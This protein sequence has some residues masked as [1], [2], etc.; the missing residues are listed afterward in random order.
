MISA[1]LLCLTFLPQE[2][3]PYVLWLKNNKRMK[4]Q[5]PPDCNA[6]RCL[7]TLLNGE[8]T[9]LP[10]GLVDLERSK[11]YNEELATKREEARLAKEK[12]AAEKA[13]A[14]AKEAEKNK[15]RR[16]V[17]TADDELP[18][19]DRSRA[20]TSGTASPDTGGGSLI[21]EPRV[22]TFSSDQPVYVAR[23]VL[24]RYEDRTVLACDV[25]V[26]GVD[27]VS[28]VVVSVQVNFDTAPTRTMSQT[29]TTPLKKGDVATA[30]FTIPENDEILRVSY[31]V[32][33][34]TVETRTE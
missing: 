26:A 18:K 7:V 3:P 8:V 30:T 17:L 33:A 9:S 13:E 31:S 12:A 23:E 1:L 5:A 2:T 10:A 20:G 21:G 4:V 14:E 16:I 27:A 25:N 15:N 19:Y 28:K 11:T 34:T 29:I 22:T 32:E 24:S 6:K